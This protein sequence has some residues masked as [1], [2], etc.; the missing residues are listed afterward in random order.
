EGI[1]PQTKESIEILKAYKTPFIVALNKVDHISWWHSMPEETML[2]SLSMQ[3]D[4]VKTALDK[5]LYEIVG[6][7]YEMGLNAERFDRVDDFTKQVTMVPC[8]GKTGEGVPELLMTLV[9]LAQK[10]LESSLETNVETEGKAIVLE[11]KEE[12]GLGTALDIILYDGS[13]KAGDTIVIGGVSEP[14]TTKVRGLL[15]PDKGKLKGV[16][17]AHAAS[18]LK[19]VAPNIKGVVAGMPLV[20]AKDIAAAEE[21][22]QKEI[23]EVLI[24]TDNQ[25]VVVKA[26]S[27][28]SLEALIGMLREKGI[29]IK[30]ASIGSITKKDMADAS[31]EEEQLRKVILAFNVEAVDVPGVKVIA[32]DVIYKIIEG[33][34][35]WKEEQEKLKEKEELSGLVK[36][37]KMQILQGCVFRQSSP[38]IVGVQIIGGTLTADVDLIK[39]DGSK[40]GHLKSIQCEQETV[41]DAKKNSEVAISLPG[42]TAGRQVK[43]GDILIVNVP[44][45][46]FKKLKELK[47]LLTAEEI[48]LLKELAEIKRKE[49]K[50]WGF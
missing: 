45:N 41:K 25:G 17:E 36:P 34:E 14:V 37:A 12:K 32:S 48:E 11:V 16:K 2:K 27:I 8:S 26:E 4:S 42:I 24:D 49:K 50:M 47:K 23:Q 3:Q 21:E 38:C 44:E 35:E 46:D 22:V 43:E 15:E 18:G 40:A 28:G 30:K 33:Y 1:M 31:A 10:F 9:G 19:I 20:V 39:I 7:L 13:I 6:K 29:E 5:K